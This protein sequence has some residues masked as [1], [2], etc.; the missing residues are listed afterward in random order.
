VFAGLQATLIP[1]GEPIAGT[2][3]HLRYRVQKP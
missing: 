2:V 1:A 3:T